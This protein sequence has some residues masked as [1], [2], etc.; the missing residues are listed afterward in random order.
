[1]IYNL[2][3]TDLELVEIFKYYKKDNVTNLESKL[4]KYW[5]ITQ[6]CWEEIQKTFLMVGSHRQFDVNVWNKLIFFTVAQK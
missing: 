5:Y 6:R 1:M 3:L 2:E 4:V